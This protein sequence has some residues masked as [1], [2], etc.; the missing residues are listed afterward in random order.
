MGKNPWVEHIKT[1]AAQNGHSYAC[2]LSMKECKDSYNKVDYTAR[3]E[4]Q[5]KQRQVGLHNTVVYYIEKLKNA[6]EQ[7]LP[8]IRSN[9]RSKPDAFKNYFKN[10]W[11]KTW[12]RY[13][14]N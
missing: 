2:A 12:D 1:W 11:P 3:K 6:N 7:Q 14:N 13:M 8:V 5:E 10:T 4:Q 9:I